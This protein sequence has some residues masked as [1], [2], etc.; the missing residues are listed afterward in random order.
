MGQG[1]IIDN[2]EAGEGR[3]DGM[4]K[5]GGEGHVEV[6]VRGEVRVYGGVSGVK[7]KTGVVTG[8]EGEGK[9]GTSGTTD[10]GV[11]PEVVKEEGGEVEGGGEA[12]E[13]VEGGEE[14]EVEERGV[15]VDNKGDHY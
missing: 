11:G 3:K 5:V 4:E 13:E 8:G 1:A 10:G 2:G 12:K 6:W 15:I 14:E 9:E 7:V